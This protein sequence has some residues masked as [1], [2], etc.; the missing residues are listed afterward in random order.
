MKF[1]GKTQLFALAFAFGW[2]IYLNILALVNYS[3]RTMPYID[4][5]VFILAVVLGGTIFYVTRRFIGKKWLAAPF[6]LVPYIFIY[7]PLLPILQT[8][9][10]SEGYNQVLSFFSLTTSG[11]IILITAL[12]FFGGILFAKRG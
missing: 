5:L 4:W 7:H 6:V 11:Y 1:L 3:N 2:L 8:G 12:G 9:V 10:S